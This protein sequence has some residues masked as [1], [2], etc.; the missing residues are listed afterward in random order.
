MDIENLVLITVDCLRADHL[1]AYGY[2]RETSPNITELSREGMVFLNAFANGPFTLASFPSLMTSSYPLQG[3]VF[4]GLTGRPPLV[5]E[6]LRGKGFR[7]AAFNTNDFLSFIPE[8]SKGFDTYVAGGP[9]DRESQLTYRVLGRLYKRFPELGLSAT[10]IISE[11]PMVNRV[12]YSLTK[13]GFPFIR[14]NVITELAIEWLRRNKGTPFFLWIHY[15][16]THNPYM[17][18]ESL[19]KAKKPKYFL[20]EHELVKESK[21]AYS[22][23]RT[24]SLRGLEEFTKALIDVYDDRIRFVDAQIGRLIKTMREE[25]IEKN[26]AVIVTADHGQAFLEHGYY[27]HIALF[28]EELVHIPLLIHLPNR[29]R[30]LREDLVSLIDIPPTILSLLDGNP[31]GHGFFGRDIITH[32]HPTSNI[33]FSEA[34]HDQRGDAITKFT[35]GD[36][37]TLMFSF[38]VRG[39]RWKYIA[40]IAE[41]S[42]VREELYDLKADPSERVNLM[43]KGSV[44]GST[45]DEMRSILRDHLKQINFSYAR[46]ELKFNII[47]RRLTEK[48]TDYVRFPFR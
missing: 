3:D 23:G 25:R 45:I 13:V 18:G 47:K 12:L 26:T 39:T 42:I 31:G 28:Y 21:N 1:E 6:V 20:V 16:D 43:A 44:P 9:N 4:Y 8:Y 27:S 35:V 11:I 24:V 17:L 22:Q 33:V 36:D 15:M 32:P 29:R 48:G 38:M 37:T 7:T 46:A 10:R 30:I 14:G 5:S 19:R 40:R 34:S 41:K 2:R